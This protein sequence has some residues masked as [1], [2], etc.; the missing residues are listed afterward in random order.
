MDVYVTVL[1]LV[2]IFSGIFWVGTTFFFVL[3]FEP[4]IK[5]VGAEGG[6][7]MGRLALTRFPMAMTIASLLTVLAGILLYLDASGGLQASWV[8]S[9]SGLALTIGGGAGILAFLLGLMIQGPSAV[10]M[11]ALQKGIQAA[12]G[13]PTSDQVQE[14][15]HLQERI[16][17]ASRWGAVL[18]LI[19]VLGMV[20]AH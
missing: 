11:S 8:F 7:V 4:T 5:V 15:H 3:F 10:R 9:L 20:M 19:A 6:K 2:H 16:A 14:L 17:S 12:G 18:M 1:R 13:V